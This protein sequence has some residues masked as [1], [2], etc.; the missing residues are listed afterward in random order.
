MLQIRNKR[1]I[2]HLILIKIMNTNEILYGL[3]NINFFE[4]NIKNC[5][6]CG[7]PLFNSYHTSIKTIKTVKG[8]VKAKYVVKEC[9]NIQCISRQ[10]ETRNVF[11]LQQS[12]SFIL[13]GCAIGI[14]VTLYIGFHMH[15]KSD[16]L[17]DLQK[18]LF[19]QGVYL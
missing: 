19:Q 4:I 7:Y 2:K 6:Y 15:I 3:E 5:T 13:P 10:P 11:Y 1:F 18:Y 16:S 12:L 14:D 8:I 17:D 9:T